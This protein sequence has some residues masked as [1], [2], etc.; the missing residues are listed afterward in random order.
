MN[1]RQL[2]LVIQERKK[3]QAQLG[4]THIGFRVRCVTAVARNIL[5]EGV[6]FWNG[7][8]CNPKA[9]S[10]G[11]GVYEVWLEKEGT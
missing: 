4:N 2:H 3:L 9:K 10:I 5:L 11:A 1:A 8:H 7:R 6:Y